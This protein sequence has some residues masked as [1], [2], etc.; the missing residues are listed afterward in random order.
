MD[1]Y[2]IIITTLAVSFSVIS[3]T[4]IIIRIVKRQVLKELKK[5][6]Y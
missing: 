1:F 2:S 6:G 4:L 3:L 5:E